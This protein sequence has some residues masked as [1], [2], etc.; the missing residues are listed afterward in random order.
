MSYIELEIN[1]DMPA[2][3]NGRQSV[4]FEL[5]VEQATGSVI[6]RHYSIDMTTHRRKRSKE[7][8]DIS[9][10]TEVSIPDEAY[11]PFYWQHVT[12]GCAVGCGPVA[13]A[14]V[15]GY[16]DRRSHEKPLTYGDGSQDLYRCGSDGT[17]GDNSCKAP[18][19][20]TTA[21]VLK[22]TEKIA[23]ALGTWCVFSNGATPAYKMDNIKNFFQER[24]SGSPTIQQTNN[25]WNIFSRDSTA[26]QTR[27][28]IRKGWPVVVGTTE[29]NVFQWHY[30]VA[31]K[32]RYYT[33]KYRT[34][35]TIIWKFCGSWDTEKVYEMFTHQGQPNNR[36]KWRN[37]SLHYAAVATY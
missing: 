14:M 6:L 32:Y 4:D 22:Y 10:W 36:T 23:D 20:S 13:W 5:R 25:F 17:T 37:M 12:R 2:V 3:F 15:F 35:V 29:D 1:K 18:M 26:I 34:C 8:K 16:Y 21:E 33:R 30:P 28:W 9:S 24:Q 27:E 7:Y 19:Y 11:F 31:T